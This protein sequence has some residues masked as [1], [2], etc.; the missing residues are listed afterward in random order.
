MSITIRTAIPA[1]TWLLA[2]LARTTFYETWKHYNTEEDLKLYMDEA[3]HPEKLRKD[4]INS[5]MNTFIL[6]DDDGKGA[7]YAKLR[8]DTS[9]PEFRDRHAVEME[10]LYLRK[11]YFG[12]GLAHAIMEHCYFI[13]G[14]ENY[15]W[16][17]LGVSVDNPRAI[18]FY[19]REGF[20]VFG[21]KIFKLGN[22]EDK[23]QLM[24]RKVSG[25][26]PD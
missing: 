24:K 7:G 22:A 18:R 10:R 15:E 6:A 2:D 3:F 16:I 17:W 14:K 26:D 21:S 4:I 19:S 1:D 20:F 5:A 13:A 8:R 9:H 12:G 23:D 25:G 11:E